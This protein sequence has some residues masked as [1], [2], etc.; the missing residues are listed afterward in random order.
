LYLQSADIKVGTKRW[1]LIRIW[2]ADSTTKKFTDLIPDH[3]R[4]T[5]CHSLVLTCF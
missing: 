5:D 3:S 1:A 2:D 4:I